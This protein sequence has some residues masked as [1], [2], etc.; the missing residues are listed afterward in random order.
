M[1]EK[2]SRRSW[3]KA[4]VLAGTALAFSSCNL[5]PKTVAQKASAD[6]PIRLTSNENPYG[7]SPKAKRAILDSVELGN[8]YADIEKVAELEK[9]IANTKA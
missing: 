7:F 8:Q 5:S 6:K 3:L 1:T 4:S 9:M 2:W